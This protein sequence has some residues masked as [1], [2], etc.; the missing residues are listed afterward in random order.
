MRRLVV[1]T[2]S[3]LTLWWGQAEGLPTLNFDQGFGAGQAGGTLSY[4]GEGGPLVGTNIGFGALAGFETPLQSGTPLFCVPSCQL[5][6]T[7]GANTA[8][9]VG[10]PG[11]VEQWTWAEGGT[12]VL[13]GTLN[14]ASDGTGT[15][16]A[17]GTL[18]AGSFDAV[19]GVVGT[20]GRLLVVGIGED[21]KIAEILQFY[22]LSEFL[23]FR[24]AQTEIVATGLVVGAN[25]S[26]NGSVTA[27]DLTNTQIPEPGTLLLFGS[28]AAALALRRWRRR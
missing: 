3:A 6:F 19:S 26:L 13:E 27:A 22:G 25:N 10:L 11:G 15:E 12:F 20:E 24:F 5:D 7:T 8:E 14:T 21:E 17:S 23:P 18:L 1:A 2:V 28:G 4:D 9:A 16:I